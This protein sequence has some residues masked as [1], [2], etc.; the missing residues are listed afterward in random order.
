[1]R[2]DKYDDDDGY[3]VW[4]STAEYDRLLGAVDDTT[5]R[6]A[7]QLGGRSGLRVSEIT[8]LTYRNV[9]DADEGFARIWNTKNE[10]YREAPVPDDVLHA[11]R[12]LADYHDRDDKIVPVSNRTVRRWVTQKAE[13]LH[14]EDG[15]RGW[16]FLRPHDLR[17]TWASWAMYERGVLPAVIFRYGGWSDWDTFANHYV[18]TLS[19][20]AARRERSKMYADADGDAEI[21]QM[22]EPAGAVASE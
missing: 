9:L 16:K 8:D 20:E 21:G 19:P 11:V 3:R 18:G 12:A 17:R 5:H 13:T 4:L 10:E 22:Y 15:N 6:L 7:I 2:L 14:A 1:M